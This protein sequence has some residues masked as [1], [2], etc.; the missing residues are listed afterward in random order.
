[1][2]TCPSRFAKFKKYNGHSAHVTSV[3]WNCGDSKLLSIG[4]AD[5][6]LIVWNNEAFSQEQEGGAEA[7]K[8]EHNS[9]GSRIKSTVASEMVLRNSR[10]GES[11]DSDTDSENEGYDS[12]VGRE[13]NI[14][15]QVR[16]ALLF[17]SGR[18]DAK[19]LIF[20]YYPKINKRVIKCV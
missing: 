18:E 9:V 5:T 2:Y 16:R 19:I 15:Y 1:M 12:D 6:S 10:R 4:G 7:A 8:S 11:D 20:R 17:F 13:F 3:R 14:D